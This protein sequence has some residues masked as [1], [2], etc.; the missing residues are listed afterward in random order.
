MDDSLNALRV[1]I[2]YSE[3]GNGKADFKEAHSIREVFSLFFTLYH[4]FLSL[5]IS[6]ETLLCTTFILGSVF[7]VKKAGGGDSFSEIAAQ[8][9][10]KKVRK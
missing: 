3:T 10:L 1:L 6:H 9:R 7:S 8:I 5:I 2:K 4:I